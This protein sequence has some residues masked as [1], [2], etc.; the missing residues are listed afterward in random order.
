MEGSVQNLHEG[1]VRLILELRYLSLQIFPGSFAGVAHEV[2][3][4]TGLKTLIRV[5]FAAVEDLVPSQ[6]R[7]AELD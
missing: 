1:L 3:I 5:G 6:R 2:A 4:L 7:H